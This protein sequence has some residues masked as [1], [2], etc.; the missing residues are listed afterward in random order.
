MEDR[1]V[2]STFTVLTL[3]DDGEGS[4]RHAILDA[5][6]PA[7]PGPDVIRFADGLSGT[8]P[9]TGGELNITDHLTIDGPGADRLAVSGNHQSRVFSISSVSGGVTVAIAGLTITDGRA[10][11]SGGGILNFGSTLVLD[12]V[13]LANNQ[14]F[15]V[16]VNALG[17][18]VANLA[19]APL[20][21][22]LLVTDSLFTENQ[23]L[24]STGRQGN[25]GAIA[26]NAGH[27][28]V[29]RSMFTN[30]QA[31]GG[32]GGANARGGGIDNIAGLTA[33]IRD[34]T[35]I[36]NQ[37]IAGD[38]NGS[39]S[40]DIGIGRGGGLYNT[41]STVTVGNGTFLGNLARGG[42]NNIRS[43]PVVAPA[44]GAGIFNE[45]ALFLTGS[46]VSGNRAV[47]GSNNRSISGD[48]DV[49]T[50]FG[51]GLNN[52]GVADVADCLFEDNEARGG[53]GNR[54]A[55]EPRCFQFVG[56][57][58]GGGIATSARSPILT[59]PPV[60][61]ILSNVMLRHNRAI[62]GDD[63]R[64]GTIVGAGIGGGLGN[65]GSTHFALFSRGSVVTLQDST[66]DHNEA[67]GGSG[68]A[69]FAGGVANIA[70]GGGVANSL[71]GVL[72]VS[73]SA[74][75]HNMAQGMDGGGCFGGGIYNGA[76]SAH[77]SNPGTGTKLTVLGA[78][79]AH[80]AALGGADGG[81]GSS[82]GDGLGGGLWNAGNA[83]VLDTA[84]SHN[85][86][87]G[88][89]G[90]DGNDGGNGFGGGVY[91]A[92]TSYLQLLQ[93]H[94]CTVSKNHANG[95]K[96]GEGGSDGEGIG[97]GVFN[98][99]PFNL[100]DLTVIGENHASTSDDDMFDPDA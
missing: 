11:G 60:S 44:G 59:G 34:S 32:T 62:G 6:S 27:L 26:N 36:G 73:G 98:L 74:L 39:I 25:G 12:R 100:D 29:S 83:L 38:G 75:T 57:G 28:T 79:L 10:V 19:A 14:A 99:G 67:V 30:N 33:V 71:G 84:I 49:G 23:V 69:A 4:L 1:T 41:R 24:G 54:G 46:T 92:V 81:D 13:V 70:I 61:L 40:V 50:A 85:H 18:A 51:G 43:G 52:L 76:A 2:P 31:I 17:G 93:L 55:P 21:A 37:A 8:I 45:G 87:L 66:L 86:A 20:P 68:G 78:R 96:G 72:T 35:F 63:N 90:A 80:N 58:T 5:N 65:N 97:G 3:A 94:G 77:P 88:G 47:G 56:T 91:N 64:A 95:G 16:G 22:T 89:A 7:Y 15:G 53:S 82:A 9:L 48:G 42:S